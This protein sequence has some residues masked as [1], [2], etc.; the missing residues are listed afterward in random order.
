MDQAELLCLLDVNLNRAAEGLRTLEDISRVVRRDATASGWLKSLR[1]QLGEL[2][3]RIPRQ[4]RLEAR[5][6]VCDAGTSLTS[7]GELQRE[8][9]PAVIAAASERVTQS[10]RVVEEAG[11]RHYPDISAECKQL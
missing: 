3:A 5:S 9:W 2:A 10:L 6:V 1:H 4:Q 11:K 7:P 8:D